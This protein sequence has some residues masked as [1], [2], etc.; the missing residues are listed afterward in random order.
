VA[1]TGADWPVGVSERIP[2]FGQP[3]QLP[4][5]HIRL[6]MSSNALLVPLTSRWS[7]E[8]GYYGITCPPMELELCGNREADVRYNTL[9]VLG[10]LEGWIRETPEQWAMWHRVWP[11]VEAEWP[12]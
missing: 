12:F 5:G 3:A 7:P 8:R 4:T 9:R 1:L 6:A 11:E 2:F 10:I